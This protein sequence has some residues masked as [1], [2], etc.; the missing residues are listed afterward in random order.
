M[1]TATDYFTKWIEAKLLANIGDKEVENFTW[2]YII[3]KFEIPRALVSD[4]GT[5]FDSSRFKAFCAGY[6]I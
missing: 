4:N 6:D 3:T 5:Q 2:R 1:I